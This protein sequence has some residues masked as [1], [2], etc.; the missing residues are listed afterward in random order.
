MSKWLGKGTYVGLALDVG[1]AE[2]GD[3]GGVCD[4][5]GGAVSEGEVCGDSGRLVGAV[6]GRL[7]GEVWRCHRSSCVSHLFGHFPEVTRCAC[8]RSYRRRCGGHA[9]GSVL[10]DEGALLGGRF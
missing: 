4:G 3:Q 9:G 7:W 8:V 5:A 10:G 1:V 6:R 2:V